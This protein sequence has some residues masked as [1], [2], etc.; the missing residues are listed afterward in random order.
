MLDKSSAWQKQV[1]V[2]CKLC[3]QLEGTESIECGQSL[4]INSV[5]VFSFHHVALSRQAKGQLTC[6]DVIAGWQIE[7]T[8]GSKDGRSDRPVG[9]LQVWCQVGNGGNQVA[10]AVLHLLWSEPD[11]YTCRLSGRQHASFRAHLQQKG[12]NIVLIIGCVCACPRFPDRHE[13]CRH[14]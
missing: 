12:L 3:L 2:S 1:H 6:S 11:G 5:I 4:S 8:P 7:M 9:R 10:A 13:A 14:E